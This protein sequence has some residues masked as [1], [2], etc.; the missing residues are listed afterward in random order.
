M[1]AL[2]TLTNLRSLAGHPAPAG[3]PAGHTIRSTVRQ[4][5][6]WDDLPASLKQAIQARTGPTTAV[7]T[8]TAGQATAVPAGLLNVLWIGTRSVLASAA[9][10]RSAETAWHART[11]DSLS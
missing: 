3:F 11:Q 6:A 2:L 5:V 1:P 7:R 10:L 8:A 4:R 9:V